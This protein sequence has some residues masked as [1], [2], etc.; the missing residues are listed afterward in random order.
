M[1]T[2][3]VLSAANLRPVPGVLKKNQTNKKTKKKKKKKKEKKRKKEKRKQN[4]KR[5][6]KKKKKKKGPFHWLAVDG[7]IFHPATTLLFQNDC[8]WNGKSHSLSTRPVAMI[9]FGRV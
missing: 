3:A 8:G 6:K 9:Y 7:T 2:L 5:K 4:K 1:L